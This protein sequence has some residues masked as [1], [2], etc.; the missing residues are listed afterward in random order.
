MMIYQ[1]GD[2]LKVKGVPEDECLYRKIAEAL[3][4]VFPEE[5]ITIEYMKWTSYTVK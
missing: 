3:K 4:V 1:S 5:E 2:T